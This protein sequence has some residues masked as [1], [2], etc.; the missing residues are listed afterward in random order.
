MFVIHGTIHIMLLMLLLLDFHSLLIVAGV[1][2][3]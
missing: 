3:S 2:L 1:F